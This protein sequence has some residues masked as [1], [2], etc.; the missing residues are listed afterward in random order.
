MPDGLMEAGLAAIKQVQGYEQWFRERLKKLFPSGS[1][2]ENT[3]YGRRKLVAFPHPNAADANM[4]F[5]AIYRALERLA[6]DEAIRVSADYLWDDRLIY[7][8]GDDYGS[9][10]LAEHSIRVLKIISRDRKLVGVPQSYDPAD[11]RQWCL[12]T[13]SNFGAPA[14]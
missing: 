13:K 2:E 6:T 10:T 7:P 8:P 1:V 5:C 12:R 11:W 3:R 4:E 14:Q 9:H